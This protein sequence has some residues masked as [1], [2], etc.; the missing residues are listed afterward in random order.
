MKAHQEITRH[1]LH[2]KTDYAR[3]RKAVRFT[4]APTKQSSRY[5]W[6][7]IHEWMANPLTQLTPMLVSVVDYRGFRVVVYPLYHRPP[8]EIAL[9]SLNIATRLCHEVR[10]LS[11]SL[12]SLKLTGLPTLDAP[13]L[14]RLEERDAGMIVLHKV[15]I[16]T[17][18]HA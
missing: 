1:L 8:L 5:Q 17:H 3:T 6:Y 11:R 2:V 18:T 15:R 4:G 14:L 16:P 7:S 12:P 13:V 9:S 10:D